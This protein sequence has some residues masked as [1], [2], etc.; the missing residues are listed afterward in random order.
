MDET[1]D[2]EKKKRR[3]RGWTTVRREHDW[4]SR[5]QKANIQ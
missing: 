4:M 3:R 5:T 1:D 2:E